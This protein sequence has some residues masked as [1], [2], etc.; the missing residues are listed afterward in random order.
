MKNAKLM[1]L[2]GLTLGFLSPN[3][4]AAPKGLTDYRAKYDAEIRKTTSSN[5]TALRSSRHNTA[6]KILP[7]GRG[8]SPYQALN[9][10]NRDDDTDGL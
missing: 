6:S 2:A 3:G 5:C 10:G 7:L 4:Y 8:K 9:E 1:V